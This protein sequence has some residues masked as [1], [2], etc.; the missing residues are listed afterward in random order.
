MRFQGFGNVFSGKRVLI[1]GHTGFKGAWLGEW[2]LGLGAQV[3]GYSLAPC[4]SPALFEQL[5]LEGRLSHRVGDV[6]DAELVQAAVNESRPDFVFHLAAQP[7]VR[8]SYTEPVA[9]FSTNVMGTINL[10]EAVRSQVR[11]CVVIVVTTDKC[12]LN[13]EWLYG[14]RESDALG[15]HDPYSASKAAAEIATASWRSSFLQDGGV[16]VATVRA[17][18]VVGGGDWAS[19]R[20][21]PDSI[22]AL[23][24]GQAIPVR[25]PL[26]TRPWQHVLEPLSGYLWLAAL[27]GKT[28]G[29]IGDTDSLQSA[30]NFG[31]QSDGNQTVGTLVECVLRHWP[32]QWMDRSEGGAPHEAR[33]LQLA[34]DKAS[35]LLGW[36]PTWS[37]DRTIAET[38]TWYRTVECGGDASDQTVSQIMTYTN[39][40][41]AAGLPWAFNE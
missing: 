37:F 25:N 16:K 11:P 18:N 10:L 28:D 29:S 40:A 39:D 23:R 36:R 32:G 4:T 31:P 14:Y 8:L 9:T 12:Y 24:S 27:L 21:V 1:T 35:R 38:V 41:A 30:F 2:L 20:I 22:R 3:Y 5:S 17:G 7:L 26:A 19:D 34:V 13:R 33:F 6:R 15:G